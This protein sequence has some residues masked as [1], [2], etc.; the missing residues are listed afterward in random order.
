VTGLMDA[1]AGSAPALW[2]LEIAVKATA[3]L[4][5]AAALTVM[6]RRASA[7]TRHLVWAAGLAGTL[8]LPMAG[9]VLPGWTVPLTPA[10]VET[11]ARPRPMPAPSAAAV[12]RNPEPVSASSADIRAASRPEATAAATPA[13][14]RAASDPGD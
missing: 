4:A 9:T 1:L 14:E 2:L 8:V 7:A 11:V 5:L 3:L 13:G 12:P 6:L 10:L